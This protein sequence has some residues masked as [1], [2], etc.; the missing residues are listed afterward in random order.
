[1]RAVHSFSLSIATFSMSE[2]ETILR[3]L[4]EEAAKIHTKDHVIPLQLF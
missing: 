1:M 2:K 4:G 3:F